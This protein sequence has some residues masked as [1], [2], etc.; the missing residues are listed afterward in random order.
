MPKPVYI[1]CA[2]S[3]IEDKDTGLFT[4]F[5][6][7]DKFQT[8]SLPPP[9]SGKHLFIMWPGLAVIN[10]WLAVPE[11]TA[12]DEYENEIRFLLP[13]DSAVALGK[14]TFMIGSPEPKKPLYRFVLRF[15]GPPNITVPGMSFVESRIRKIGTSDEWIS[16][17]SPIMVEILPAPPIPPQGN[18]QH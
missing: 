12:G 8:V 2:Q 13:D 10:A 15:A 18:G 14:M 16:Q 4:A 17:Q 9:Q 7:V 5:Q 1:F 6:I 3:V 11:D